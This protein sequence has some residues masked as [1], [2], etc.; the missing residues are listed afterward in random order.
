MEQVGQLLPATLTTAVGYQGSFG[1][2]TAA[3]TAGG[4]TTVAIG[5]T[6]SWNGTAISTTTPLTTAR[7]SLPGAGTQTAGLLMGGG[8][9]ASNLAATEEWTGPYDT[10]NYKT[11][12]TS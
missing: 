9:G 10:L 6:Y 11:L 12:T 2:Q 7:Y 4:L 8:D 3:I 1:T 5:T